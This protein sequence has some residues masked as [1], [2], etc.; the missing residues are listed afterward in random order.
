MNCLN[1]L[2]N[3]MKLQRVITRNFSTINRYINGQKAKSTKHAKKIRP[4]RFESVVEVDDSYADEHIFT[5]DHI[6][7]RKTLRKIIEKEINPYVD[8]WEEE[9]A[10]PA[11]KIFKIL[12]NAGFLG[13]NKPEKYGGLGLDFT[14]TMAVHEEMSK[15]I[16]VQLYACIVCVNV[17]TQVSVCM[18]AYVRTCMRA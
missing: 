5:E 2:V 9:E 10:F 18:H 17:H 7:L 15:Y 4:R 11:H 8:Q 6:A 16:S 14:Y 12:G 1:I 3:V 13:V